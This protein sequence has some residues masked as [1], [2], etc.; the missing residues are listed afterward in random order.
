FFVAHGTH[1]PII[2]VSMGRR[3]IFL[4]EQA[5]ADLLYKEYPMAH[6]ISD[7]SLS[8]MNLWLREKLKVKN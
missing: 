3:A 5:N 4:L 6:Q 2:P 8:D 7:E 1:D